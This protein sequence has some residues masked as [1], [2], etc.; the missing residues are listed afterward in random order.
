MYVASQTSIEIQTTWM[1]SSGQLTIRIGVIVDI[2][3]FRLGPVAD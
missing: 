1:A 2:V 3:F